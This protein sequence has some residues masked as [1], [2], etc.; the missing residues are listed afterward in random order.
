MKT[1]IPKHIKSLGYITS[2]SSS[3][4]RLGKS[5]TNSIRHNCRRIYGW[6]RRSETMP[7]IRKKT[8][9]LRC[10][11][12]LSFKGFSM[13]LLTTE[14]KIR[15]SGFRCRPLSNIFKDSDLRWNFQQ[16]EKQD[17]FKQWL[18]F[19]QFKRVISFKY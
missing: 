2:Y 13:I 11:T 8:H 9:F 1:S 10:A 17:S 16:S 19:K 3:S 6:T 14:K 7:E 15:T 12:S 18:L 5:P 4:P